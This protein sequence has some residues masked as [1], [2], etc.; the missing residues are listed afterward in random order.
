MSEDEVKGMD[1]MRDIRLTENLNGKQHDYMAP[2]LWLHGEDI[3]QVLEELQHIYD[4]GIRSVCLESR[5]H[6]GFAGPQWW[7]DMRAIM[8]WCRKMGMKVW[9]LDD[10]HFPTGYAN[11]AFALEENAA[12]RPWGI[13]ERHIDVSG[14]VTDGCAMAEC[15]KTEPEDEITAVLACAHVPCAENYTQVLDITDGL[16]DG[17]VY[18]SL[19]EGMWRIVFLIKTRSGLSDFSK[20][21]CNMLDENSVKVFVDAVYEPHYENL[22]EYFGDPFLGFFSDEPSFR[23]NTENTFITETGKYFAHY[24]WHDKLLPM[25]EDSCGPDARKMLAGLWFDIEGVSEKVRHAYM[26]MISREYSRNF[27]ARLADWCHEHGL[28]Y[29]GHIIEDNNAHAKTGAGPGHYFRALEGQDMSGIDVVLHQIVPGLTEC[30]NAGSVCYEHMENNFFQYYLAKLGSSLAHLDPKKKGRAMCEIFGAFGWAEGTR[31]MKYLADHMLVRGINYFVPHAFSPRPNDPDCPPNFYDTG[32]NALYPYFHDLMDY[33]NRVCHLHSGGIHVPAAA[34]LY[35]AEA[36]WVNKNRV[37]LERCAKELYDHLLDYDILP[38]DVLEQ[39]DKEGCLNGEKY[40]CLIVPYYEGIPSCIAG[41]LEKVSLRTIL[42]AEPGMQVKEGKL[43]ECCEIV[44]PDKLAAYVRRNVGADVTS[45]YQGIHLRYYHY[46]RGGIHS[47][48]FTNEDIHNTIRTRV[49]LSA[50]DGGDYILYDAMEN[51]AFAGRSEDGQIE[52]W[53]P[54]YHSVFL[55]CGDIDT[56]GLA[57]VEN[58][59]SEDQVLA[60]KFR[61]SCREAQQKEYVPFRTTD[62]LCNITGRDALPHF[63]GDIKYEWELKIEETGRYLLDL[64]N[65]GEAAELYVNGMAIGRRLAPPYVFDVSK[66]LQPGANK[67]TV[68]VSN[69]SGYRKRDGF[70]QFLL[71]EPS[72]LLGPVMLKRLR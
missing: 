49:K 17:M 36:H 3:S 59:I 33:M 43:A 71:F 42:V 56:E 29:I 27:C 66:M 18:F 6:E 10:K 9:I 57:P 38:A 25:L 39:I 4:S 68:V 69:H 34:I 35:D 62:Q 40:P 13:T 30:A 11:G 45:D 52:L 31:Y 16:Q 63:S 60:P 55:L 48:M 24:P 37:P 67:V 41:K 7:E 32:E 47:Y 51:S 70:S 22:K 53:L 1:I 5:T 23:N 58:R 2:F 50:F 8:D 20:C 21:Y 15:W 14:P 28:E 19:P 12:L 64:G 61:I 26:D 54:S 65:V 46:L 44:E 72:G